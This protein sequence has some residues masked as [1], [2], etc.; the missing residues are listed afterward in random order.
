MI[1]YATMPVG[2]RKYISREDKEREK[3]Q[4]VNSEVVIR[5]FDVDHYNLTGELK[6]IEG[7]ENL[8]NGKTTRDKGVLRRGYK[9]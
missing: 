6:Y 7:E 8:V 4:V 2:G 5:R 1:E 3:Q 9:F